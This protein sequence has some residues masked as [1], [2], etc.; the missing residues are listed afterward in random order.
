M[1]NAIIAR[2][3]QTFNIFDF[4]SKSLNNIIRANRVYLFQVNNKNTR[5]MCWRCFKV[6]IVQ[7]E[8]VLGNRVTLNL[9]KVNNK[10]K[11]L[12]S[13]N[14]TNF[15]NDVNERLKGVSI[16]INLVQKRLKTNGVLKYTMV[17]LLKINI[18]ASVAHSR[19]PT[20]KSKD[21][22]FNATKL[23]SKLQATQPAFNSSN[24]T[25]KKT[26]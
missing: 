16:N 9:F 25:V 1:W 8:Q 6:F 7:F 15:E 10:S 18:F 13:F 11:R 14:L 22:Q 2:I 21:Y 24:L 5:T 12:Q 19:L 26:K 20:K 23:K 17:T 4:R 3:S